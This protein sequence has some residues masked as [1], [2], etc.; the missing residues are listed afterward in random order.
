[1]F[2]RLRCHNADFYLEERT[3]HRASNT[4]LIRRKVKISLPLLFYFL[5]PGLGMQLLSKKKGKIFIILSFLSTAVVAQNR[6]GLHLDDT[7][8]FLVRGAQFINITNGQI[9]HEALI[10]EFSVFLEKDSETQLELL[11]YQAMDIYWKG[12]LLKTVPGINKSEEIILFNGFCYPRFKMTM[13]KNNRGQ[14]LTFP[15]PDCPEDEENGGLSFTVLSIV[16][17]NRSFSVKDV[18]SAGGRG[19]GHGSPIEQLLR[20][21][22]FIMGILGETLSSEIDFIK[23]SSLFESLI[24]GGMDYLGSVAE[25]TC[26]S[27]HVFVAHH[28]MPERGKDGSIYKI[29]AELLNRAAELA[30][31]AEDMAGLVDAITG[32]SLDVRDYII[33]ENGY[34]KVQN[35]YNKVKKSPDAVARVRQFIAEHE[36]PEKMKKTSHKK[37]P[38]DEEK[39]A[40]GTSQPGGATAVD[41]TH[42]ITPELMEH[43]INEVG[44]DVS[45]LFKVAQAVGAA[46]GMN[47]E[48]F[49][50]T[51]VDEISGRVNSESLFFLMK[52]VPDLIKKIKDQFLKGM[53]VQSGLFRY[54]RKNQQLTKAEREPIYQANQQNRRRK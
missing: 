13:H 32:P 33:D 46:T 15:D 8:S 27:V 50:E 11:F 37:K 51:I 19:S 16:P 34:V 44:G 36:V 54:L 7:D 40:T 22:P 20:S 49:R 28:R 17:D 48:V 10:D 12:K 52:R 53:T 38:P 4:V 3:F 14:L 26:R 21:R 25:H 9:E 18:D 29:L 30:P 24:S 35:I 2:N 43:I 47:L 45:A 39:G 5:A 1:M 6:A 41:S 31:T 23:D 42:L